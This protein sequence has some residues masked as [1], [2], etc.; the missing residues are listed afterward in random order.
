MSE[1][2]IICE[3]FYSWKVFETLNDIQH[4]LTLDII[5]IANAY[6]NCKIGEINKNF[7]KLYKGVKVR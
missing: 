3:I 6:I 1:K 4:N 7:P 5:L 2:N